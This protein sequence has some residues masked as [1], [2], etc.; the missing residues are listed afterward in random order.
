MTTATPLLSSMS[1]PQL[2]LELINL[3]DSSFVF[4][5]RDELECALKSA[6]R[7]EMSKRRA[8]LDN[9]SVIASATS[10]ASTPVTLSTASSSTVSS[11][12]VGKE[13]EVVNEEEQTPTPT[14]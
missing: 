13:L 1:I 10:I 14:A 4:T 11:S 2:K 5:R 12:V 6:R 7:V 9:G 8:G 3:N